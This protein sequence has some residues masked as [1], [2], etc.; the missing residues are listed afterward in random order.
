MLLKALTF[1]GNNTITKAFKSWQIYK[2][3]VA[4]EREQLRTFWGI[5]CAIFLIDNCSIY[6]KIVYPSQALNMPIKDFDPKELEITVRTFDHL[7]TKKLFDHWKSHYIK[8]RNKKAKI[9]YSYISNSFK[10]WRQYTK[11]SKEIN[12]K[13][14]SYVKSRTTKTLEVVFTNFRHQIAKQIYLKKTLSE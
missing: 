7:Y 6:D 3:T 13:L 10:E 11:R 12:S 4:T 9:A 8:I 1:W 14:S 5:R 2:D